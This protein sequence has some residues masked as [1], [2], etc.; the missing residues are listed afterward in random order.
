MT[1]NPFKWLPEI[2]EHVPSATR[3][4]VGTKIDLRAD[5]STAISYEQVSKSCLS[6]NVI[7]KIYFS[8]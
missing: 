1:H 8:Y 7:V 5:E 2:Y 3:V 6:I 4:L